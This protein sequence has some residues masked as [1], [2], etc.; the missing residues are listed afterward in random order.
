MRIR[1][2]ILALITS[3]LM[4][5][6]ILT[7]R[8]PAEQE[9]VF[10]IFSNIGLLYLTLII[11]QML[12]L[13]VPIVRNLFEWLV[14]SL[15]FGTVIGS[16]AITLFIPHISFVG[17]LLIL[18]L[19]PSLALI[20]VHNWLMIMWGVLLIIARRLTLAEAHYTNLIRMSPKLAAAYDQRGVVRHA[21]NKPDDALRDFDH[22]LVLV[23]QQSSASSVS[24]GFSITLA[25]ASI[26]RNRAATHVQRGDYAA[27]IADCDAGL[28]QPDL[29]ANTRH[30][31]RLNRASAN[32]CAGD[33]AVALAE[34]DTISALQTDKRYKHFWL[35]LTALAQQ[36]AGQTEAARATWQALI[37]HMPNYQKQ[38]WLRQKYRT[39][40]QS[41]WTL[42][43]QLLAD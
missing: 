39:L 13:R 16:V 32:L 42:V 29:E 27:A 24:L 5:I 14:L 41:L 17:K 22:A 10:Q 34:L 37:D 2:M 15:I 28:A 25:P 36:G 8:S 40:P 18:M 38:T 35:F 23:K 4:I 33:Y 12:L 6:W 9:V 31:L 21:L 1:V 3:V 43:D 7:P 19:V 30:H 11:G 20:G 26:L